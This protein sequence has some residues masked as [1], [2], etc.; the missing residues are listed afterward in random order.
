MPGILFRTCIYTTIAPEKL[1]KAARLRGA[2]TF[3]VGQRMVKAK[4]HF[5][6]AKNLGI[7]MGILFSDS[8]CCR[9]LLYFSRVVSISV[10]GKNTHI[11]VSNLRRLGKNRH[12]WELVKDSDG[13]KVS[14]GF[15]RPYAVVKTPGYVRKIV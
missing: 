10:Q 14:R 9:N 13:K 1:E 15:I 7:E 12:T 2:T 3:V 5:M 11:G 6:E 4:K 8:R